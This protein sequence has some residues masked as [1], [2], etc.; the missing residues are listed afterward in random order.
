[1]NYDINLYTASLFSLIFCQ[2]FFYVNYTVT[3]SHSEFLEFIPQSDST[4]NNKGQQKQVKEQNK[5]LQCS[6]DLCTTLYIKKKYSILSCTFKLISS[7][8]ICTL[9]F[10]IMLNVCMPTH[11]VLQI[12]ISLHTLYTYYNSNILSFYKNRPLLSILSSY[13]KISSQEL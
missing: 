10:I 7:Q 6:L 4:N 3:I 13:I 2:E 11:I 8:R 12:Y 1:M 5:N 9:H